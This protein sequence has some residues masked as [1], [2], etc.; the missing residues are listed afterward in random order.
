MNGM[1]GNQRIGMGGA[2]LPRIGG[3]MPSPVSGEV[4]RTPQ[5]TPTPYQIPTPQQIGGAMPNPIARPQ[6][7]MGGVQ[8]EPMY[9]QNNMR[10]FMPFLQALMGQSLL[11]TGGTQGMRFNPFMNMLNPQ[12][13][14]PGQL[15][16]T[17]QGYH[18]PPPPSQL[19]SPPIQSYFPGSFGILPEV[20]RTQ[21]LLGGR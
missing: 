15:G 6:P 17:P 3:A 8:D 16:G 13:G 21:S 19:P 11:G 10:Q 2:G 20:Y 1:L 18:I 5:Q 12:S 7:T 9:M 4:F 14:Q